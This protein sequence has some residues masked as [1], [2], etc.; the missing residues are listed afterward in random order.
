MGPGDA[1]QPDAA[2]THV[3]FPPVENGVDYLR[4]VVDH[5]TA[6]DPPTP[7]D[8]K[9]AVLHIQAAAEV[10]LKSRLVHEHWSLV[11]K[12]PGSATRKKFESGDFESCTTQ[13]AVDRLRNVAD[14]AVDD[15]GAA[16]LKSL[17]KSRNAL[18]H[19]GLTTSA[20]AVEARAAEV[21]DFLMTFVHAELAL[22]QPETTHQDLDPVTEDLRYVQARLGTI[23]AFIK[24]RH[25]Q[26]RPE[27]QQV[28]DVT[29][30]CSLCAQW[31]LVLG[32]G[33]GP[34]ACRF[35]HIT[36]ESPELA[37]VDCGIAATEHGFGVD[38]VDCPN[39]DETAVLVDLA[40]VAS[41]PGHRHSACFACGTGF[42]ELKECGSCEQR[43]PP[44]P[45]NDFGL[46]PD[47]LNARIDRF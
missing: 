6:Y 22:A 16:A 39:C 35:C 43:Y 17:A 19:Y 7:R 9:Y 12:E 4:S 37:A 27:L 10:L 28:L 21:L 33:A 23:K 5:L 36:W 3:N 24:R 38:V 46:C 2:P 25:D 44:G 42:N 30:Q 18:Q 40:A 45:D 1:T 14:V 29:V 11:F 41:A 13:A 32:A 34:I 20:P 15:K 26:L 47:C 8:L 31:A